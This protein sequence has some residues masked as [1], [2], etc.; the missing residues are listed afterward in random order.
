MQPVDSSDNLTSSLRSP[1]PAIRLTEHTPLVSP[2]QL[3]QRVRHFDSGTLGEG[4]STGFYTSLLNSGPL[5]SGRPVVPP[6]SQNTRAATYATPVQQRVPAPRTTATSSGRPAS[7]VSVQNSPIASAD[8]GARSASQPNSAVEHPDATGEAWSSQRLDNPELLYAPLGNGS[9]EDALRIIY[10]EKLRV[11]VQSIV[12]ALTEELPRDHILQQLLADPHTRHYCRVRLT[13]VVEAFLYATQAQQYHNLAV[14]L[15][16]RERANAVLMERIAFLQQQSQRRPREAMTTTTTPTHQGFSTSR[17]VQTEEEDSSSV[18]K[19]PMSDEAARRE[20]LSFLEEATRAN[21]LER[22]RA[23]LRG[24]EKLIAVAQTPMG[25]QQDYV[26]RV[27]GE[28]YQSVYGLLKF[29]DGSLESLEALRAELEQNSSLN[30]SHHDSTTSTPRRRMISVTASRSQLPE[31]LGLQHMMDNLREAQLTTTRTLDRLAHAEEQQRREMAELE[32][33]LE[34][35]K[36]K[37]AAAKAAAD[38][39]RQAQWSLEARREEDTRTAALEREEALRQHR[40]LQE[41]TQE[42]QDARRETQRAQDTQRTLTEELRLLQECRSQEAVAATSAHE[43]AL[44]TLQSSLTKRN[45]ELLCCQV[46]LTVVSIEALYQESETAKL[47]LLQRHGYVLGLEKACATTVRHVEE[48]LRHLQVQLQLGETAAVEQK[49]TQRACIDQLSSLLRRMWN[50]DEVIAAAVPLPGERSPLMASKQPHGRASRRASS[51]PRPHTASPAAQAK[52]SAEGALVDAHSRDHAKCRLPMTL[53]GL[54]TDVEHA[55]RKLQARYQTLHRALQEARVT[56]EQRD[57]QIQSLTAAR[58]SLQANLQEEEEEHAQS[59]LDVLSHQSALKELLD[60]QEIL[61][62]SVSE[63]RDA[64]Q[65]QWRSL[66]ADYILLEKRNGELHQRCAVKEHE[67]ARLSGMLM[68]CAPNG[69]LSSESSQPDHAGTARGCTDV[70]RCGRA[71][72][73]P[74]T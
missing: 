24:P 23:C 35:T 55:Y 44:S 41:L 47:T 52:S 64:L 54:A 30:N 46:E 38:T 33:T 7:S 26:S 72:T 21:E 67:N 20:L 18:L 58:A 74:V 4:R 36:G 53:T 17:M 34:H 62:Q 11:S 65:Q 61:L 68:H 15:A 43:Q 56:I 14:E 3:T 19:N 16:L 28:L 37:A 49:V 57:H 39:A 22:C 5:G 60:R 32:K 45:G 51:A 70:L 12:E 27:V 10:G 9:A 69:T 71:L 42:L 6:S 2:K 25:D 8:T 1:R 31:R 13:E 59:A 40:A 48:S 63:E 73:G 29:V 66:S 50:D